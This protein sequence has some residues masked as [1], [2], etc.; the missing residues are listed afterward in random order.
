M[1]L[2]NL[3]A[4]KALSSGMI[5]LTW[6]SCKSAH[7]VRT[8]RCFDSV[9]LAMT[10]RSALKPPPFPP[11][12]LYP[13]NTI[14]RSHIPHHIKHLDDRYIY[15][16]EDIHTRFSRSDFNLVACDR[17]IRGINIHL[18]VNGANYGNIHI[19]VCIYIYIHTKHT[20]YEWLIHA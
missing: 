6:N 3:L 4:I 17:E 5:N 9:D 12:L 8:L 1:H 11:L 18:N 16:L 14:P 10:V 2:V 20:H 15:I 19:N 13:Q 7:F